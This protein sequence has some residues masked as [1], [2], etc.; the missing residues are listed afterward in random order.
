MKLGV[1]VGS[2][3]PVHKGHIKI[4]NHLLDNNYVDK[5][6]IIPTGSYWNKKDMLPIND[7]INMLKFYENNLIMV[8]DD[9]NHLPYTYQILN[10]LKCFNHEL[11]LIIGEDN[12]YKFSLWK[13]VDE[14]LENKILVIPRLVNECNKIIQTFKERN[15]FIIVN[16]FPLINVSSTIIRKLLYEKKYCK[17]LDYI[18][19]D[20]LLYIIENHLY[21]VLENDENVI[22]LIKT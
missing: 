1:Y 15:N 12:L 19:L 7:R 20:V 5:V 18:D 8:N 2:F 13:N 4:V 14:I 16:D 21:N 9:L 3:N 6:I 17:I 11:Y 22:K 10:E